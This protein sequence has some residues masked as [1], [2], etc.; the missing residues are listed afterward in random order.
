MKSINKGSVS[1]VDTQSL[2]EQPFCILGK[3]ILICGQRCTGKTA[4]VKSLLH[5]N[6]HLILP[7]TH[8]YTCCPCKEYGNYTVNENTLH[9]TLELA[10]NADSGIFIF[11][12]SLICCQDEI[13]KWHQIMQNKR[14][15]IICTEHYPQSSLSRYFD[16]V[17]LTYTDMYSDKQR[18]YH[19]FGGMFG[20]YKT[21]A[22][23]YDAYKYMPYT[24][25]II[26]QVNNKIATYTSKLHKDEFIKKDIN[27]N[28]MV[29]TNTIVLDGITK[30][31]L[32]TVYK[33]FTK[34]IKQL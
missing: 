12:D 3:K 24:A 31:E 22:T 17:Y 33:I 26:N 11:D 7:N 34:I 14:L 1:T 25:M 23:T 4:I 9:Q 13:H 19:F 15:T 5:D 20:D 16:D 30:D 28:V 18:I 32:L 29:N 10:M 6:E 2:A 21:F 27:K 8:I